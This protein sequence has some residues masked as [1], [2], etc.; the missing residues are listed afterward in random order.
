M[1]TPTLPAAASEP[2]AQMMVD[3]LSRW[4]PYGTGDEDIFP[5]FGID[6]EVFYSRV[7]AHLRADPSLA[8]EGNDAVSL[9]T[10]CHRRV[11]STRSERS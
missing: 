7:A 3:F 6:P 1:A 2:E 11:R 5:T 9:V 10:Y 4:A 8:R